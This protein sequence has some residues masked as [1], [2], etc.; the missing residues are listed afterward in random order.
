MFI[1]YFKNSIFFIIIFIFSCIVFIIFH[2]VI[3]SLVFLSLFFI[4]YYCLKLSKLLK[5]LFFPNKSCIFNLVGWIVI[6]LS[7]RSILLAIH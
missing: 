6:F 3:N 7:I 2:V 4:F 5:M 1:P